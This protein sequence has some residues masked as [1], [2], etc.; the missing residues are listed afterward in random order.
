MKETKN[1]KTKWLHLR[2]SEQ[3]YNQLQKAFS[4]TTEKKLSAYSRNI[5]LGIPMIKGY[6]NLTVEA[7]M[8]EFSR[9]IKELNGVTNNFNQAIHKLH[10]LHRLAEFSSW[11]IAYEKDRKI[12]MNDIHEIREFINVN[13][14]LWL[15][16]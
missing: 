8:T 3:E 16:S 14:A 2:L 7:Q 12:V 4:K 11:L 10:T 13:A 9:L 6:R 1:N 15:Q 5:L